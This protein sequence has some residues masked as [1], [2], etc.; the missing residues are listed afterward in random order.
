MTDQELIN[1][2]FLLMST[3]DEE[4]NTAPQFFIDEAEAVL[5]EIGDRKLIVTLGT[6][7]D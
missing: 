2:L 5:E 6:K 7:G 3:S 1:K 4:F